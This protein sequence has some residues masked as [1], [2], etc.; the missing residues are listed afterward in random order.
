MRM[1]PQYK[2]VFKN[3]FYVYNGGVFPFEVV[4]GQNHLLRHFIH[5][6]NPIAITPIHCNKRPYNQSI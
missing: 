5:P 4:H 6:H 3:F 2:E 1:Y